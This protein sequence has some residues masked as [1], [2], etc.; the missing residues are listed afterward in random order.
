MKI[1]TCLPPAWPSFCHSSEYCA[2]KVVLS[3]TVPRSISLPAL[4]NSAIWPGPGRP[5]RSGGFPPCTRVV[6][7]A[8]RSRVPSY[9]TLTPVLSSKG[10]T[11]ARKLSCS[12]PPQVAS[13]LTEPPI[14][15]PPALEPVVVPPPWL[16]AASR[17]LTTANSATPRH[18]DTMQS[19]LQGRGLRTED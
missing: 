3:K 13:T 6:S 12:S 9:W 7:T 5:A 2:W 17:K 18:L 15:S 1:P 11:I 16:Q 4:A 19:L 10:L 8:F 14:F